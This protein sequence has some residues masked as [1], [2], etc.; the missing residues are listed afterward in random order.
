MKRRRPAWDHESRTPKAP[1][2]GSDRLRASLETNQPS[3]Q[4]CT[5]LNRGRYGP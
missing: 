4:C 5:A 3:G 1:S 2:G